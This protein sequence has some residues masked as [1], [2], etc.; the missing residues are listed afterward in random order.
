MN[1]LIQYPPP[2]RDNHRNRNSGRGR[3]EEDQNRISSIERVNE[4]WKGREELLREWCQE[5]LQIH[6]SERDRV[7]VKTVPPMSA[8]VEDQAQA[9][10]EDQRGGGDRKEDEDISQIWNLVASIQTEF[11]EEELQREAAAQTHERERSRDRV[12]S[13]RRDH[14]RERERSRQR[15]RSRDRD[16]DRD[17]NRDWDRGHQSRRY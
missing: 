2:E 15:S 13:Y 7:S 5:I 8:Q 10:E 11:R 1:P 9:G 6:L 4:M 16:R 14:S 3:G 17:R 12:H